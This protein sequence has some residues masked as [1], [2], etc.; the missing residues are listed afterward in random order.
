MK[1]LLALVLVAAVSPAGAA[2]ST[3]AKRLSQSRLCKQKH[4][5]RKQRSYCKKPQKRYTSGKPQT[6]DLTAPAPTG[7]LTQPITT[8]PVDPTT[9]TPA[10]TRL[11][12]ETR[13]FSITPSRT[14]VAAGV[15][16]IQLQNR[17]ED[18]HNLRIESSSGAV[19]FFDQTG[20]GTVEEQRV[21]LPAGSY[22]LWCTLPGHRAAGMEATIT[23]Q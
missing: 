20:P 12:V 16:L 15:A 17:G 9:P 2:A 21:T 5:T 7:T 13:E 14:T 23:V 19:A 18:P 22:T 3:P 6:T 10:L 4:L 8:P 1:R 11:G